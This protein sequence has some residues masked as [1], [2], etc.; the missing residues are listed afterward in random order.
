MVISVCIEVATIE[1]QV[2]LRRNC[3]ES[4]QA[5]ASK[6]S[7]KSQIR[8]LAGFACPEPSKGAPASGGAA[9]LV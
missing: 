9:K 1:R 6:L 7:V 2:R 8:V 3:A 5:R 4:E